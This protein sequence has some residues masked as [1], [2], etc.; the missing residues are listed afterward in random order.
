MRMQQ[1]ITTIFIYESLNNYFKSHIWNFFVP[2]KDVPEQPS[3]CNVN[4][5]SAFL[6]KV[7]SYLL[8][9][10]ISLFLQM[11]VLYLCVIFYFMLASYLCRK[12][13]HPT[14]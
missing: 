6:E 8:R 9:V 12:A 11:C 3:A 1:Y 13:F 2:T 14:R 5:G 7:L 4:D 10:I